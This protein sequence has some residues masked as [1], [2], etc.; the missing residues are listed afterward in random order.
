[1]WSYSAV[2]HDAKRSLTDSIVP[3]AGTQKEVTSIGRFMPEAK[4]YTEAA[5]SEDQLY[6][7]QHPKVL[8][9]ATHGFFMEDLTT[10]KDERALLTGMTQQRAA[11]DP[12][13]RS[14]LLLAGAEVSLNKRAKGEQPDSRIQDG[15]LTAREATTLQ[16][17]GT[18]LVVLSACETGRGVLRTGEGVF[19]LQR[20]FQVAGAKAVIQSLWSVDDNATQLL[21]TNFYKNWLQQGMAKRAAFKAAQQLL[22]ES[23]QY[24][25]PYY[26]AGFVFVGKE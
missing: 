19:G 21:M 4:V 26:W 8:H 13:L 15:I 6:T 5:A 22:R 9:L 23:P 7:L 14:G 3:L 24:K 10:E 16:L 11:Q 17:E 2:A 18:E 25:H 20:A 1:M 12:L